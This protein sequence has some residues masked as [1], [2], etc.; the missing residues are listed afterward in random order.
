[1]P[2]WRKAVPVQGRRGK[3]RKKTILFLALL[4]AFTSA[5]WADG[6]LNQFTTADVLGFKTPYSYNVGLNWFGYFWG[7]ADSH[8]NVGD[9]VKSLFSSDDDYSPTTYEPVR[10]RRF[11][12][13]YDGQPGLIPGASVYTLTVE[14]E[15]DIYHTTGLHAALDYSVGMR[16]T[17]DASGEIRRL[18][19]GV[20][21]LLGASFRQRLTEDIFIYEHTGLA[22]AFRLMSSR[23]ENGNKVGR[24][25]YMDVGLYC[26]A[27]VAYNPP[28]AGLM[29]TGGARLELLF[30]N[31]FDIDTVIYVGVGYGF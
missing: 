22:G 18:S 5:V 31:G 7:D 15:V 4:L 6:V 14:P 16:K 21:L 3:L 19:M 24:N 28:V 20:D 26:D 30:A 23:D 2:A 25:N 11:S 8:R 10:M 12:N 9:V 29:V 17:V 13:A 1:M 27:G